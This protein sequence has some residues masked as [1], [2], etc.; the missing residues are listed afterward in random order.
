MN[1]NLSHYWILFGL[2]L[3]TAWLYYPALDSRFLLDD[4]YN[5]GGLEQIKT[6][7]YTNFILSGFSG[8]SGR[9]LSL[10]TFAFQHNYWP[11]SPFPFKLVNLVIHLLCG[12]LL[13]LIAC[14]LLTHLD[15]DRKQVRLIA[16]LTTGLWLLHPLQQSTVLY[17][18]QRMTQL[19]ALF[20][21]LG[22]L[23]YI[24]A[25]EAYSVKQ[26]RA[27]LVYMAAA[28]SMGI[29]LGVLSKENGILLPLYILAVEA[30][31]FAHQPRPRE[32][33]IWAWIFL[34]LPLVFLTFYLAMHLDYTLSKYQYRSFSVTER[35]MTEPRVLWDYIYNLF[36]PRPAAYSVY[37]DDYLVST[38]LFSPPST[39]PAIIGLAFLLITGV[40]L[41]KRW[42]VPAFAILWF[43]AGHMLESTYLCL[44]LYFEHRNYLP[45]FGFLLL[46]A[47]L[48]VLCWYR[49]GN[50]ILAALLAAS[51]CGGVLLVSAMELNL[52]SKPTEQIVEW[53]RRHPESPRAMEDMGTFYLMAGEYDKAVKVYFRILDIFPHEVYPYLKMISVRSCY[54]KK[55]LSAEDW[56]TV[57]DKAREAKRYGFATLGEVDSLTLN[58]RKGKC[59]TVN[60][61]NLLR[62]IITLAQN[63]DYERDRSNFHELAATLAMTVGDAQ[64]TLANIDQAINLNPTAPRYILK[65]SI[66][67]SLGRRQEAIQTLQ[68]FK[69]YLKHNPRYYVI[70]KDDEKEFE[71]TLLDREQG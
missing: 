40:L 42:P 14:R 69:E 30:T 52:W 58:I 66:L 43:F 39:L 53:Q 71:R 20:T 51:V 32:W 70:Y 59:K 27:G 46:T 47:W 67:S 68:H 7:G 60:K 54:Q 48:L 41:R 9:P 64:V 5:I 31:F 18:V 63:P 11:T 35:L 56:D 10:L 3:L 6:Q 38:G 50:K 12:V 22:L 26:T 2:L 13:Y 23:G 17:V 19:S 57:L 36:I 33:R 61:Y 21:L 29:V 55:T 24:Y 44:E 34:A 37:H 45:I 15:L 16:L 49:L 65:I 1:K 28:V 8:P 62:L 25:R 4:F